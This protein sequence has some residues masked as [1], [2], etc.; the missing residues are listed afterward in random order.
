MACQ[1]HPWRHR[2]QRERR[3]G[4]DAADE[5]FQGEDSSIPVYNATAVSW[6]AS[7]RSRLYLGSSSSNYL[8][9]AVGAGSVSPFLTSASAVPPRSSLGAPTTSC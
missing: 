6:S 7:R 5:L 1:H 3:P 2:R 9:I 4:A 8:C